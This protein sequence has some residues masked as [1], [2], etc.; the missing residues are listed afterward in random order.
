MSTLHLVHNTIPQTISFRPPFATIVASRLIS[1][2]RSTVHPHLRFQPSRFVHYITSSPH[3]KFPSRIPQPGT[4]FYIIIL[5]PPLP[6]PPYVPPSLSSD[7]LCHIAC[8]CT[9]S[10]WEVVVCVCCPCKL[11][12]HASLATSPPTYIGPALGFSS[13]VI[14]LAAL[15]GTSPSTSWYIFNV[16]VCITSQNGDNASECSL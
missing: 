16:H 7:Y 10:D 2:R 13:F 4:C 6:C 12:I 3:E 9:L 1:S 14:K 11:S 5:P 15:Y 8:T